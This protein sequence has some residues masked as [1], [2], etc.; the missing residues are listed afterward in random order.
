MIIAEGD[1][2][3]RPEEKSVA[4]LPPEVRKGSAFPKTR[5]GFTRGYAS[6]AEA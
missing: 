2:Q 4:A 1:A 5:V 6:H 3:A